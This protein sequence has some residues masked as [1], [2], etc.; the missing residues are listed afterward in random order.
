VLKAFG[1]IR[2]IGGIEANSRAEVHGV[3]LA[4]L[5]EAL[6]RARVNAE[7]VGRLPCR[8]QRRRVR[9][10]RRLVVR[11][12]PAASSS[13]WR[14]HGGGGGT[15]AVGALRAARRSSIA[16]LG[17]EQRERELLHLEA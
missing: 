5:D 11:A 1:E 7:R 8:Q 12:Q 17:L 16:G 14:R 2:D 3:Q 10:C 13:D 15:S 4:A 6:D 9:C